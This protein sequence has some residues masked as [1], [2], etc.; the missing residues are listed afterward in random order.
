VKTLT[1]IGHTVR[2]KSARIFPAKLRRL[3]LS[4]PAA[5]I[6]FDDFARTA[7]TAGGEIV[8]TAGARATYY[9]SGSICGKKID[10][11]EFFTETD[12]AELHMRGHEVGCHT[13]SHLRIPETGRKR[14]EQ[15][16]AQNAAFIRGIT[17]RTAISSF[18]YPFGAA[19]ICSKLLL[20]R[21]FA[22]CRG[23]EPG[24]NT[25]WADFSQLR[26]I[27]LQPHILAKIPITRLVDHVRS[28]NGWII[29]VAH[30]V[31]LKPTRYGCTPATLKDAI[32]TIKR[33]GITFN[34]VEQVVSKMRLS[35]GFSRFFAGEERK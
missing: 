25:A 19:G 13:F 14:I 34:T 1:D 11:F 24:T 20:T 35:T 8:E 31:S 22:A 28:R 29:L 9:T 27:S 33:A 4:E 15:D 6:T 7:W 10:G 23:I 21:H 30:D 18:A 12:L 2:A 26:A 3:A 17:G 32:D 16:L 5:S